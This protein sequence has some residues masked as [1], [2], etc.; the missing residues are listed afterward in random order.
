MFRKIIV[1]MLFICLI[2]GFIGCSLFVGKKDKE[3]II[4]DFKVVVVI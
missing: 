3:K 2:I 4:D 1:F